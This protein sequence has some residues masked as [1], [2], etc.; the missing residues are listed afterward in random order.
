MRAL[1]QP[2]TTVAP[3][4]SE[5]GTARYVQSYLLLRAAVGALG[6]AL[7]A[8]LVFTDGLWFDGD[9]FPRGSLSAYYYSGVRDVLVGTICAIGTFLLA[10]KVT[11]RNLDNFLSVFAGIT[12]ILIALFP[13][14]LPRGATASPLQERLGEDFCAD[15]HFYAAA[16]F[17]IALAI[18]SGTFGVR[19]GNRPARVGKLPPRFWRAYH[20]VCAGLVGV[21]LVYMGVTELTDSGPRTTLLI[22]ETGALMAFG[23]SWLAKGAELD[24]LRGQPA[25]EIRDV[26]TT[27]RARVPV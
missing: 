11:E 24:M 19:E 6:V 13:P 4:T 2:I 16:A 18:L 12:G 25:R 1:L 8:V 14:G 26:R 27:S 10:Y 15:A 3:R 22:G 17:L 9:P 7:P 23:A 21:A 5:P 20:L